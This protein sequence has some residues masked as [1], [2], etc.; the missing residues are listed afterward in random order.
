MVPCGDRH[1]VSSHVLAAI[2]PEKYT[3]IAVLI[4]TVN[5]PIDEAKAEPRPCPSC[6]QSMDEWQLTCSCGTR[7]NFC[8]ATGRGIFAD[9]SSF[10]CR[11]CNHR[12]LEDAKRKHCPLCHSRN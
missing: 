12:C 6:R 8:V 11:L 10:A 3:P 4:F 7:V 5:K 9:E 1:L 2:N